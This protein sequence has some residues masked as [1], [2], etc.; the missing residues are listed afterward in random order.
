MMFAAQ[1]GDAQRP[2]GWRRKVSPARFTSGVALM[3]LGVA[4]MSYG[5]HF[6]AKTGNCSGTGYTS[7]GPVPR[8]GGGEP[9]YIMS[10]FFAGPLVAIGGWLLAQAWGGLWPTFCIVVGAG[11]ITLRNETTATSGAKAF[12]MV[13]GI[14]LFGLAVLS[15]VTSLRKRRKRGNLR[16]AAGPEVAVAASTPA[17]S[18]LAPAGARAATVS[19][20]DPFDKIAKLA[21]LR[22]TGAL[23][24]DEFDRE[25]AKLLAEI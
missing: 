10:A 2:G 1:N 19:G 8:C 12:G 6:L 21:L 4:L 13:G 15:V 7:Y 3:L 20:S 17:P 23:T 16:E 9:L 5:A 25:K 11:L 22:D 24:E 18:R 14:C